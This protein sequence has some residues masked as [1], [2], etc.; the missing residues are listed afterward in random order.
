MDNSSSTLRSIAPE[1][2]GAC[3]RRCMLYVVASFCLH[4]NRSASRDTQAFLRD[5][6]RKDISA[7]QMHHIYR[8]FMRH[9]R[10]NR[11]VKCNVGMFYLEKYILSGYYRYFVFDKWVAARNQFIN[12][13]VTLYQWI[14]PEY[15]DAKISSAYI[16][17]VSVFCKMI[18]SVHT[19][20]EKLHCII[21]ISR[22]VY[23]H[24]GGNIGQ[25]EFLPVFIFTF[26]HLQTRDLLFNLL[27]IQW[28]MPMPAARCHGECIHIG[29]T[30]NDL[31]E[32]CECTI[33]VPCCS[34][35][36][37]LFYLTNFEAAIV[38]IERLE[39][40]NL[41]VDQDTYNKQIAKHCCKI[42]TTR[43]D[44]RGDCIAAGI[45]KEVTKFV[46]YFLRQVQTNKFWTG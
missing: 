44:V 20:T 41:K 45:A 34:A 46:S 38:F 24:G 9:M 4:E 13:K 7:S 22:L 36:E 14:M 33:R 8:V 30:R 25:E 39:Y 2:D 29:N 5:F 21:E 6:S 19:P 1:K 23:M 15:I 26:I 40:E 28:Y 35:K 18:N 42:D 10:A 32:N 43:L 37:T 16:Q 31:Q 17:D 27:Y 11:H 12:N 3:S